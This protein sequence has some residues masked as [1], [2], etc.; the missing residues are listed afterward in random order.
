[1]T[2]LEAL[3]AARTPHEAAAATAA[4]LAEVDEQTARARAR[5]ARRLNA[6]RVCLAAATANAD[7][8]LAAAR[9][10]LGEDG[11]RINVAR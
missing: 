7:Q 4:V 9:D 5:A 1:M 3:A 2:P 10:A 11:V 8:A 6:V